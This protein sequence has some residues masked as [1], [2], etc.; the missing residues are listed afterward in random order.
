MNTEVGKIATLLKSASDKKTPL[1]VNLDNFGKRLSII[2]MIFCAFV[3][4]V[5]VI[6]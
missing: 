1:Q 5:N 3:F 6:T 2:I 4:G